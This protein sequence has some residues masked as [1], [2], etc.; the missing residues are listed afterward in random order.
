[1]GIVRHT[2]SKFPLRRGVTRARALPFAAVGLAPT[3][4]GLENCGSSG[5]A[6]VVSGADPTERAHIARL[7]LLDR[8]P[9]I[10]YREGRLM[11]MR[12]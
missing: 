11:C 10:R 3:I 5:A 8:D 2:V 6:Q 7:S 1:M 4:I 9:P 12:Q